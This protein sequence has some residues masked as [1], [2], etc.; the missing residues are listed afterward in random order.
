MN[1]PLEFSQNAHIF[2]PVFP[3]ASLQLCEKKETRFHQVD[4]DDDDDASQP[5]ISVFCGQS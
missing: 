3:S 5:F 4:D 1:F 2:I